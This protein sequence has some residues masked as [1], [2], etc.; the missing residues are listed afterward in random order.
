MNNSNNRLKEEVYMKHDREKTR[1]RDYNQM[2]ENIPLDQK[3][4]RK[5]ETSWSVIEKSKAKVGREKGQKQ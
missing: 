2:R 4:K 5:M 3:C 1:I